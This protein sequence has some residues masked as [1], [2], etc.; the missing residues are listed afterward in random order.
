MKTYTKEELE[1]TINLH[2]Q[3]LE[4][5]S[6]GRRANL[7]HANLAGAY[8]SGANLSGAKLTNTILPNNSVV[9][10]IG[11]FYA[12]K[13]LAGNAIAI[14]YVPKSA[15]RVGGLTNRKC[16]VSKAKVISINHKGKEV[17]NG[18]SMYKSTFEY[19]VGKWVKP[20]E[21]FNADILEGCASGIH[22]FIT[23]IEAEEY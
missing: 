16:R 2:K 8:L 14:L 1:D 20:I 3:W 4:R 13:K 18:F 9:P 22:C 23:K 10:E 21:P 15:G 17:L 11:S 7:S 5:V 6:G 12:F 19:V